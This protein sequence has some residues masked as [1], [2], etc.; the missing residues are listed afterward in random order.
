MLILGVSSANFNINLLE[1]TVL[2]QGSSTHSCIRT[3]PLSK[4]PD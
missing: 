3:I 1:Y 2:D 4:T